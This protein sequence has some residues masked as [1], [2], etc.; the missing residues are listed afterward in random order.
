MTTVVEGRDEA[1]TAGAH[2]GAVMT[3]GEEVETI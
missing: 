1:E 3:A 2:P